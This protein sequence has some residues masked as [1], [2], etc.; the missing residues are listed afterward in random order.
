MQN[1]YKKLN[2]FLVALL[3]IA[4]V[5]VTP[6][7]AFAQGEDTSAT[8]VEIDNAASSEVETETPTDTP[9]TTPGEEEEAPQTE[10]GE[11]EP[12]Q[13][14]LELSSSSEEEE[15]EDEEIHA[16]VISPAN[17]TITSLILKQ[18]NKV[19]Q[20]ND[21]TDYWGSIEAT[22]SLDLTGDVRSG[23]TLTLNIPPQLRLTTAGEFSVTAPG[24]GEVGRAVMNPDARTVTVTFNDYF[25]TRP[26]EKKMNLQFFVNWDHANSQENAPNTFNF[27]GFVRTLR[28][29][30][31]G[32]NP[33][34]ETLTKWG[35][36]YFADRDQVRWT[37]RVN[38]KQDTVNN[39]VVT[40][41]FDPS[42]QEYVPGSLY[43]EYISSSVP[44]VV[45]GRVPDSKLQVDANGFTYRDEL[46]DGKT[47][48]LYYR[49]RVKDAGASFFYKNSAT[50]SVNHTEVVNS[51]NAVYVYEGGSGSGSATGADKI[52]LKANKTLTGR[53]L[54]DGEFQF[55]LKNPQGQ[56]IQTKRNTGGEVI[57]DKFSIKDVGNY[58][59]TIEEVNNN[60]PGVAYDTTP[61]TVDIEIVDIFGLKYAKIVYSDD[62][63]FDNTFK[64][65]PTTP[66]GIEVSKELTGRP[67]KDQEFEFIL[68]KHRNTGSEEIER[69]KNSADG[70]VTFTA[71]PYVDAGTYRYTVTEVKG[72]DPTVVY[73]EE[74]IDI[75][76]VVENNNGQLVG[77]VVYPED[78]TFNNEVPPT[79]TSAV[80]KASLSGHNC[81]TAPVEV[82]LLK[83]DG[84][85]VLQTVTAVNGKVTFAPINYNT[86]GPTTYKVR[87]KNAV[88]TAHV[89]FDKDVK[90]VTVNVTKNDSNNTLVATVDPEEVVFDNQ[91]KDPTPTSATIKARVK[92]DGCQVGPVKVALLDSAGQEVEVV[93][94]DETTGEVT[95]KALNFDA[96]GEK[97]YKIVQRDVA[98]SAHVRYDKTEKTVTINVT[99]NNDTNT[100]TASQPE[101]V[102][103]NNE[104]LPPTP[105][106]ATIKATVKAEGCVV[107]EVKV[108]L[109]DDKGQVVATATANDKGEVSFNVPNLNAAK[110]YNYKLRQ[111][112]VVDT[113]HVRYDKA[114]KPV[115]V[116]V[117]LN[118]TTNQFEATTP[119]T[120][121]FN[122]ECLPPT[123]T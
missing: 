118:N 2:N 74:R 17:R 86:V 49:T 55:Q 15:K 7:H 30:S 71:I 58:R 29:G 98:D 112:D 25:T 78:K 96:V 95:F 77:R 111:K 65:T 62:R 12:E 9:E 28:K 11:E 102:V 5:F 90:T 109:V 66:I 88:D 57:F 52:I 18:N 94:A 54:Q 60:L 76:V 121:V 70:K 31:Q 59:Y 41:T 14:E 85:T 27:E 103:F 44:Y 116:T 13:G 38:G 64:P 73:S 6:L 91:C 79:P 122:N 113:P 61:V 33:V 84:T 56:V 106:T 105:T 1:W 82:E 40:D 114:E 92:A 110:T 53:P 81:I 75:S 22:M 4:Q 63:T 34:N 8:I 87:Q 21:L 67:L 69:V 107:G 100:L 93:T 43:G 35:R 24:G 89:I 19:L 45:V 115:A 50:Y 20:D 32:R 117:T 99:K 97:T 123:P 51:V 72:T 23:D 104:C 46:I 83:E 108:E 68:T 26:D 48:V 42:N 101:T 10:E 120:V 80:I 16:S 39:V 37:V 3:L 47:V 36:A 119:E